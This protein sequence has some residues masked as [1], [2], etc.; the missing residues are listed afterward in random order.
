M[1]GST[2][3]SRAQGSALSRR[4]DSEIATL[5]TTTSATSLPT[6][7]DRAPEASFSCETPS[8]P[9]TPFTVPMRVN[10]RRSACRRITAFYLSRSIYVFLNPFVAPVVMADLS[11]PNLD[12]SHRRVSNRYTRRLAPIKIAY[13][14]AFFSSSQPSYC[15]LASIRDRTAE[16]GCGCRFT[17][18]LLTR[19]CAGRHPQPFQVRI[20]RYRG[21]GRRAL[22]DLA[23]AADRLRRQAAEAAGNGYER[24][25]FISTARRTAGRSAR[26]QGIAPASASTARPATSAPFARR[27]RRR[28]GSC[29]ACPRTRW[30]C[31]RTRAS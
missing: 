27:R 16:P 11:L 10:I 23:R 17:R 8:R 25:G 31:R 2:Y 12:R 30:T 29:S 20:G 19:R 6:S 21:T 18:R 9:R 14:R 1:S 26:P 3:L 15:V 7:R 5:T 4:R 28:A 24:I 13:L 22:L